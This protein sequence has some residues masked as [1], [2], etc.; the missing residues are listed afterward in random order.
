MKR[1]LLVFASLLSFT[2]IQARTSPGQ[3]FSNFVEQ[4]TTWPVPEISLPDMNEDSIVVREQI[5]PQE[6]L[7]TVFP[8][9]FSDKLTITANERIVSYK[10]YNILG[11]LVAQ[12]KSNNNIARIDTSK[13][14]SGVYLLEVISSNT[15]TTLKVIKR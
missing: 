5:N 9:P 7:V 8:N 6:A 2:F 1:H 11:S 4:S 13:F 10:I 12:D 3:V 15:K 14:H